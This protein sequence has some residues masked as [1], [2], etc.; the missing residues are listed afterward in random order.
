MSGFVRK[1]KLLKEII[2]NNIYG[3]STINVPTIFN[4]EETEEVLI[5]KNKFKQFENIK[6]SYSKNSLLS[7]SYNLITEKPTWNRYDNNTSLLTIR[8]SGGGLYVVSTSPI[9]INNAYGVS[10][11]FKGT[12]EASYYSGGEVYFEIFINDTYFAKYHRYEN[13]FVS[14]GILRDSTVDYSKPY[15][16]NIKIDIRNVRITGTVKNC[17]EEYKVMGANSYIISQKT[18]Q[19]SD[20]QL[21]V[22]S[23]F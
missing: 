6:N 10:I 20:G 7:Y 23:K 2:Q 21:I 17:Y 15:A 1:R 12:W 3:S 16:H 18:P 8:G 9:Y 5:S 19:Y 22:F 14:G 4:A 13:N 11:V